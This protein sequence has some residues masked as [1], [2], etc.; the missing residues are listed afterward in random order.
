M[1]KNAFA[2]SPTFQVPLVLVKLML[3]VPCLLLIKSKQDT[4]AMAGTDQITIKL[5][6][7]KL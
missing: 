5:P 2:F 4:S 7:V 3:Y 6:R 1:L